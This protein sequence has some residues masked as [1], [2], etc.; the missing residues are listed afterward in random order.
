MEIGAL[1][2][3]MFLVFGI[4]FTEETDIGNRFISFITKKLFGLNLNEMED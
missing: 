1:L 2:F 4:A 3:L